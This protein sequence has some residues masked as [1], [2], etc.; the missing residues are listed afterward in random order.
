MSF[1]LKYILQSTDENKGLRYDCKEPQCYLNEC[2]GDEG[3]SCRAL[4]WKM[5]PVGV[6]A[7]WRAGGVAIQISVLP[8]SV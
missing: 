7:S 4:N 3:L 1:T 2:L 8:P 6:E 5:Y